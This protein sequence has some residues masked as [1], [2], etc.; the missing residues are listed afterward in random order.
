M[1]N[2][3]LN[4]RSLQKT[5]N[6]IINYSYGFIDGAQKGKKIFLTNIGA[7]T[8]EVL[9]R[10]IDLEARA[11]QQAL[12]HV[13]EWYQV[14][15]PSARLFDINYV[16][17]T[18]GLK[19]TSSFRQSRSVSEDANVPFFNKAKIMEDGT[20]VTI[21][22]KNEVLVFN[23]GGKTVF[24]RKSVNIL[25]PGGDDVAGSFE[26]IFDQFMARYFTQSFLRASG[27]YEHLSNPKIY[28]KNLSQGAKFGRS[29]GVSTGFKWIANTK[30]E[31]E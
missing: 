16:V 14:G 2:I 12:H 26:R 13:Y 25:N 31:V 4:D 1:I 10:Y 11:N 23:A 9:K 20:P 24:T 8:V 6:N 15:S 29:K 28:K 19:I 30:V 17:G 7:S 3:S 27:I 22:P 5:M 21:S 18:G